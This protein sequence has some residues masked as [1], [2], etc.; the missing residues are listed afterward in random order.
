MRRMTRALMAVAAICAV[1][2]SV[3]AAQAASPAS[4]TL[5]KKVRSLSW[6]GGP[7]NGPMPT[8]DAQT[9]SGGAVQTAC[10]QGSSDPICD[11]FHLKVDM[12]PRSL[13]KL[14]MTCSSSGLEILQ[15]GGL[16]S[17]PNDFDMY[18][19]APDGTEVGES[20]TG[21]CHETVTFSVTRASRNKP[22]EVRVAPYDVIPGATYT[23]KATTLKYYK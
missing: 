8:G 19:Y 12:G 11:H 15:T 22:Y 17:S 18:V 2:A 14:A 7:F 5:N 21:G 23:V 3:P 1:V 16:L 13:I 6:K 4:G 9:L 10:L 20:V